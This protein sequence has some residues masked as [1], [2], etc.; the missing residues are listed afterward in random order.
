M[1]TIQNIHSHGLYH[2][3]LSTG[4][5]YGVSQSEKLKIVGVAK[6]LDGLNPSDALSHKLADLTGFRDWLRVVLAQAQQ[7]V[8]NRYGLLPEFF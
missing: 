5:T 8:Y 6:S 4:A 1:L 3:Q 7:Y 2:G